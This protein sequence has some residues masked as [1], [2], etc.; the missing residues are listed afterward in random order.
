MKKTIFCLFVLASISTGTLA[1]SDSDKIPTT[2]SFNSLSLEFAAKAAW[3]ALKEC[4]KQG[5]SI[6][7]AVVDRGGNIQ[8]L[9][10]DESAGPHTPETA[11]R[12]AWS[13]N[14]FRQSTASLAELLKNGGMPHQAGQIP[15]ILLIPGALAIDASGFH[16]GAI[17]AS[18]APSDI[19]H[20]CA[21]A[22]KEAIQE[23]LDFSDIN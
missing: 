3:G 16:L 8:A 7:V 17:G 1:D 6:A 13:A 2:Y 5:Y 18:G 21:I 15:G 20:E 4:R 11:V 19:D 22:G 23:A 12:K 14:T 10:R 9:L